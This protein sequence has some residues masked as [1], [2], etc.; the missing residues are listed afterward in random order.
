MRLAKILKRVQEISETFSFSNFS[1]RP[2]V[3]TGVKN[4]QGVQTTSQRL[5]DQVRTIKKKGWFSDLKILEIHKKI[6]NEQ[7]RNTISD[8]PSI[9]KPKQP[10]QNEPPT[11]EDRN[12]TH[13]NNAQP[14]NPEQTLTQRAKVNLENFKRIMNREKIT[15]TEKH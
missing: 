15:I 5:G 11:S 8:M 1:K 14:N 4:S 13:P 10:N 6:N 7:D 3:K 12:A 9:K 2:P